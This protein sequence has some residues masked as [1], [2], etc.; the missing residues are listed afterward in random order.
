MAFFTD[1]SLSQLYNPFGYDL[2]TGASD[3]DIPLM[4]DDQLLNQLHV[5]FAVRFAA[6]NIL[7]NADFA[8]DAGFFKGPNSVYDS[9]ISC[10][11]R[12]WLVEYTWFNGTIQNVQATSA[13]NGTISEIWH[14]SQISSS[15]S[16]TDPTLEAMLDQA[17]VMNSSIAFAQTWADLYSPVIMATIGGVSSS[18]SNVLQQTR[19]PVLVVQ[20]LIPALAFLAWC[21]LTYIAAGC[22]LAAFAVRT[23]SRGDIRDAKARLSLFGLVTWA[24]ASDLLQRNEDVGEVLPGEQ[25][26]E[27]E[28]EK[29]GLLQSSLNSFDFGI[30]PASTR[31]NASRD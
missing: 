18:R 19:V 29:V 26:I 20:V 5:A 25:N 9:V 23:A 11:Y 1:E 3:P 28:S 12:S 22:V 13:P 27:E 10:S 21:C 15:V 7:A 17:A 30:I 14:G 8:L 31:A 2:K 24:V 4:P 6:T 16:G